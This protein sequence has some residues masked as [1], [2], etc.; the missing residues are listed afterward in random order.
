MSTTPAQKHTRAS[1]AQTPL[2]PTRITRIQE[3]E[4]LKNLN[5]RLAVYIDKVRSLECE[6]SVLQFKISEKEE[7]T[8]RELT[9]I[10]AMYE[11]ELADTRRLLDETAREKAKLQIELG[12]SKTELDELS[13]NYKKKDNDLITAQARLKDFE[14]TY[15][16]NEAALNTALSENQ[17]MEAELADLRSQL[18]K[19]ENSLAAAKKQ[20]EGE[21]LM[22]V[23]L[24]NQCQSL[25]EELAFRKSVFEEE[26]RETKKRQDRRVV[27][28]DSARKVDYESKLAEALQELRKQHEDQVRQYKEDLEQTFQAKLENAKIAYDRNDK[29]MGTAREELQ[30]AYLRIESLNYQ[31]GTLQKQSAASEARIRELEEMLA[32]DRDKYRKMLEARDREMAELRDTME[33]QLQEYEDLLDVKLAL[34][35]EIQAYR[36]LLEGEEE[37]LKLSPSPSSRVTVSRATS[38]SAVHTSRAKRKRVEI[39]EPRESSSRIQQ[40]H[41]SSGLISI[42]PTDLEGKF[43]CLSNK[44]EKDQPLGGWRLKRQIG[45]GEEMVYKFTPKYTLK[46]GQEVKIWSADAG[47]AH[48][49]PTDLLWKNHS[50]G[51]GDEIKTVLVNSDGEDVAVRNL[52]KTYHEDVEEEAEFGEEDLFHQQGDPRTT[53][54]QCAVM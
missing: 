2:S 51:T 37:R 22:R 10:K 5:D 28:V 42:E 25:T 53:S 39:E 41:S 49:P 15:H 23:D 4:E 7:V 14:L 43:V 9:G 13:K 50:W 30:E 31:L 6:N 16:K 1:G 27:E 54:R 45:D 24:E 21:T 36:K 40:T 8:T 44:S 46:A 20:L 26:V 29:A 17:R 18:V 38:S 35:M 48:S 11:T 19:A 12:K 32:N 33:V 3:K 47:K 34:D 52:R